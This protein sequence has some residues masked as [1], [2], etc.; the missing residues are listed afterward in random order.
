MEPLLD[1]LEA[2]VNDL[3]D[4][5]SGWIFEKFVDYL[6]SDVLKIIDSFEL[7]SDE[8]AIDQVYWNG[9]PNG[10]F[11]IKCAILIVQKTHLAPLSKDWNQI[12][13]LCIPPCIQFFLWLVF[14]D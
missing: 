7:Q 10:G 6:P 8:D 2:Y 12:W 14:H 13:K 4:P 1:L 11:S 9:S 3:W 5:N